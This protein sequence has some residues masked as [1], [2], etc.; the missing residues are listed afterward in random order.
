VRLILINF[1]I[2]F[3]RMLLENVVYVWKNQLI[4]WLM[5]DIF[6]EVQ[7]IFE[8][9]FF[10]RKTMKIK[11]NNFQRFTCNIKGGNFVLSKS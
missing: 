4:E 8:E 10:K 2:Q 7:I 3:G 1:R 11:E 5:I 9:A 6:V